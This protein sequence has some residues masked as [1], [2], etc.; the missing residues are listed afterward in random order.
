MAISTDYQLSR[1]DWDEWISLAAQAE[2]AQCETHKSYARKR[3]SEM[4]AK[5]RN[6]VAFAE[7]NFRGDEKKLKKAEQ[8]AK[9]L[10]TEAQTLEDQLFDELSFR[11]QQEWRDARSIW[12]LAGCAPDEIREA[13]V[14]S[15]PELVEALTPP[16]E[17]KLE[18]EQ[19]SEAAEA[20]AEA[21]E[22]IED[23]DEEEPEETDDCDGDVVARQASERAEVISLE[24]AR[25]ERKTVPPPPPDE[26]EDI[27]L[28]MTPQRFNAKREDLTFEERQNVLDVIAERAVGGVRLQSLGDACELST[29][30]DRRVLS[31]WLAAMVNAG[32]LA[33][34]GDGRP[35][36]IPGVNFQIARRKLR[37]AIEQA[38]AREA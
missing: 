35:K 23:D 5:A 16:T 21:K 4:I 32:Y 10:L 8:I 11:T 29:E 31:L 24:R 13:A 18:L 30:P 26:Q 14:V 36:F 27:V 1:A 6:V 19:V 7:K 34:L 2:R 3:I 28:R 22:A 25:E 12:E 38:E 33:C 17:A 20:A 9:K 37:V 15:L